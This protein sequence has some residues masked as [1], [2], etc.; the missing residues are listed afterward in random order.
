MHLATLRIEGFRKLKALDVEFTPGL[1]V[2]VGPN[3]VGKTA[4][5]DAL[6]ALLST[7]SEGPP[8]IDEYDLHV[9]TSGNR[10]TAIT[11]TYAFRG[12]TLDDEADFLAA[13]VPIGDGKGAPL[14]YEARFGVRYSDA[15]A[16]GRLRPRRWC[17][18]H[19][20]NS[21]SADLLE[22]LTAVYLPPLRDPASGLRPHRSSQVARLAVRLSKDAEKEAVVAALKAF[23]KEV[24]Q[25]SPVSKTQ[26]AILGKHREMLGLALAQAVSLGLAPPDFGRLAARLSLSVEAF[27]IEQNGLGYNNLIYMAVVLSELSADATVPYSALIVEEPE[28][29][30][31][32]QLQAVLLDYLQS[33]GPIAEA[34]PPPAPSTAV[35]TNTDVVPRVQVFVTSHSPHF[36]SLARLD[37]LCCLHNAGGTARAFFPRTVPFDARTKAK[38]QRYLDVT[39]ASLFFAPRI[40]LVEGAAELFVVDALARRTGF[41]LRKNAVSLLSTE[42][43]NFDAFLPLF[44]EDRLRVR[45]AVLTDGDPGADVYPSLDAPA[46]LSATAAGLVAKASSCVGVFP[47]RKSL[48]YDLATSEDNRFLMLKALEDI[49]PT[50]AK[51]L[52]QLLA[53]TPESDRSRLLYQ[54]LFEGGGGKS[55]V[56]KGAFGQALAQRLNADDAPFDVPEYIAAAFS[57][58]AADTE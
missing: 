11:F 2:L 50:I 46:P 17:G 27:D 42:G 38:L 25:H 5:M 37:C 10:A 14:T 29:H 4:V 16:G 21:V 40:L 3:N 8:R 9:D 13:L 55:R 12:L 28:A 35:E 30:L 18:T 48:E 33:Q 49:H 58:I 7:S 56:Q 26:N 15:D 34:S 24:A 19:E 36:A 45:L 41:D 47:A 52:S 43:L 6:R 44:G 23:D 1:N 54:E 39:R 32:P 51:G 22:S 53:S 57:F 20:D 31:H